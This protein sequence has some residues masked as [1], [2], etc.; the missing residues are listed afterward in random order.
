MPRRYKPVPWHLR[1]RRPRSAKI[2]EIEYLSDGTIVRYSD[3]KPEDEVGD[4][5]A[6]HWGGEAPKEARLEPEPKP[7][8]PPSVTD[9]RYYVSATSGSTGWNAEFDG[10]GVFD[11]HDREMCVYASYL[12]G[13]AERRCQL[14]NELHLGVRKRYEL[15]EDP[16]HPG[17]WHVVDAFHETRWAWSGRKEDCAAMT[18]LLNQREEKRR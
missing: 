7:K 10:F 13:P 8:G 5:I 3:D 14:M 6:S 18:K 12:P 9:R 2:T 1:K 16:K 15:K 11:S 4:W 17:W